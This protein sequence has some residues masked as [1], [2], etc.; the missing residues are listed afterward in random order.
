MP[1]PPSD[2]LD[3]YLGGASALSR[4]YRRESTQVPA[5][6]LDRLVL[7]AARAEST[8]SQCLAPMAFAASVFLSVAL[9][10]ALI[11]GPPAKNVDDTPHVVKVR[12][13]QNQAAP[14]L[15]AP[16]LAAP[17]LAAPRAAP[18]VATTRVTGRRPAA[19]WLADIYA[20]RRDGH[21]REAEVEMRRFR[22]AYPDYVVTINE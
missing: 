17:G 9:V 7:G 12:E 2:E 3:E 16:G 19:G 1:E 15:A 10:L 22:S 4:Q 11:F 20:L 18:G 5:H 14:G 13:Y 6:A 21:S 8:K